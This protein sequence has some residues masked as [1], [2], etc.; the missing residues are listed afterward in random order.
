MRNEVRV[1]EATAYPGVEIVGASALI[2]VYGYFT[3]FHD[4]VVE[5]VLIEKQ[6]PTVTIRFTTCDAAYQG[7]EVK[8]EN[9]QAIVV[10]RWHEVS[11][12]SVSGI[13][14]R[15]WIGGLDFSREGE[16]IRTE[17]ELMDGMRGFILARRVEVVE[18]RRI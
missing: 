14:Q 1:D 16:G 15:N 13:D 10:M 17:L 6:G 9:Q 8:D 12:L 7:E 18:V 2:A 4:A 11:D 3:P 5:S